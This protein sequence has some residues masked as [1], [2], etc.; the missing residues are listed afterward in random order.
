MI[1]RLS[2]SVLRRFR[3][4]TRSGATISPVAALPTVRKLL[5]K[6]THARMPDCIS[7][8]S[9]H[10]TGEQAR[11]DLWAISAFAT[12]LAVLATRNSAHADD[13]ESTP[14]WA[15][16]PRPGLTWS[17]LV[18]AL[19]EVQE[20]LSRAAGFSAQRRRCARS[21][22]GNASADEAVDNQ[23]SQMPMWEYT[24][25][26]SA[27]PEANMFDLFSSLVNAFCGPGQARVSSQER[28]T[29]TTLHAIR[30]NDFELTVIVPRHGG[31]DRRVILE[32]LRTEA[33]AKFSANEVAALMH[34]YEISQNGTTEAGPEVSI[35]THGYLGAYEQPESSLSRGHL[36]GNDVDTGR[37]KAFSRETGL[38][39]ESAKRKLEEL[40]AEVFVPKDAL[41]WD[42]LGKFIVFNSIALGQLLILS[43]HKYWV[44]A[45][46][47]SAL[48]ICIFLY[49]FLFVVLCASTL[50]L[51]MTTS[52]MSLMN[53][54][55]C[56]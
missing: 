2:T 49:V 54:L 25:E 39:I 45:D 9:L 31:V 43:F 28:A 47:R 8:A 56:H 36:R 11:W 5:A 23:V 22:I 19:T 17:A 32:V 55:F 37:N 50:K 38:Q 42:M 53:P 24:L 15:H 18:G 30:D 35:K 29:R 16:V 7:I 34:A 44:V 51:D 21:P 13:G 52:R 41:T 27:A 3:Y 10:A 6:K 26:F 14:P 48:R 12:S 4:S 40:G 33:D 46:I 20:S 1:S